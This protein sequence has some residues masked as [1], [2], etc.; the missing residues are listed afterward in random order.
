MGDPISMKIGDNE[1]DVKVFYHFIANAMAHRLPKARQR[2]RQSA[3]SHWLSA[4]LAID[5][6][7]KM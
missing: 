4:A 5:E 3:C 6:L 1:I 2:C 7:P